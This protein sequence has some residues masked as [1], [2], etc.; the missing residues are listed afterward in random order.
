MVKQPGHFT[1]MKKDRGA[2]TRVWRAPSASSKP[3]P[4]TPY[5]D[6]GGRSYLELVLASLGSSAGVEKING[7]NLAGRTTSALSSID[8]A[9]CCPSHP[10]PPTAKSQHTA[11]AA[12]VFMDIESLSLCRWPGS[13]V[14]RWMRVL[15]VSVGRRFERGTTH[16]NRARQ[17]LTILTDYEK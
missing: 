3:S 15:A 4:D 1:S 9:I 5:G 7:E 2:G 12:G 6:E 8:S 14:G 17:G 11:V 13:D 10:A 16:Q